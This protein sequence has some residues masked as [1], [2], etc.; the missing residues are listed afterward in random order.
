MAGYTGDGEV[1]S[2]VADG[3]LGRGHQL[4]QN[5]WGLSWRKSGG[6]RSDERRSDVSS[7]VGR[8]SGGPNI[9]YL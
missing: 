7:G 6:R 1:L 9:L 3:F 2:S 8:R 5:F 4:K